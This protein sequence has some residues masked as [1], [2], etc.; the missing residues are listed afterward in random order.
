MESLFRLQ[1][2]HE[3]LNAFSEGRLANVERLTLELE[4]SIQDFQKLLDKTSQNNASR[5]ALG[6]GLLSQGC[7]DG[8][9]AD[10]E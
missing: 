3:D 5:E 4:A 10:P 1:E 6:K 2:L 7:F 9:P 8:E